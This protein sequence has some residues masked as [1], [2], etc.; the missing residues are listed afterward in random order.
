[1]KV[2]KFT[3]G[4]DVKLTLERFENELV[5][6]GWTVEREKEVEYEKEEN[7]SEAEMLRKEAEA[8]GLKPHHKLGAEKIRELINSV[9][10]V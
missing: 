2:L 4:P 8:L 6:M 1:M 5:A 9:K 10:E 3:R 7:R